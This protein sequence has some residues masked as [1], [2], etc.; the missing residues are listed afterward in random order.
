VIENLQALIEPYMANQYWRI[1]F[2]ATSAVLVALVCRLIVV[3]LFHRIARRT[4]SDM[5]EQMLNLIWPA[6]YRTIILQGVHIAAI[7]FLSAGRLE[8]TVLATTTTLMVLIW[9]RVFSGGGVV[10]FHKLSVNAERFSWIQ[11]QTLPLVQFVYKVALFSLVSYMIMAAWHVN[12]TSWLASAG[13]AG[14]ALGFAAKDTLANFVSGVFI[15]ADA[16]Y[17]VGEYIIID[18]TTRGMVTEIGMRSTRLL[19][20]DNVEVTVPNGIIGNAKIVNES[21]GPSPRMRVRVNVG[22]AYGSDIDQVRELLLECTNELDLT[23]KNATPMIRFTAMGE[24]SL[25]F[26]VLVWLRLPEFRGRV[27]NELNTRIYKALNEAGIE[28]PFPQRDLHVKSWPEGSAGQP[29]VV[30]EPDEA[31]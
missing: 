3:P 26:Q 7:D 28:I 25:D 31:S 22:V 5:D 20:R 16:P 12:L 6:I 10:V 13:V 30:Q 21:S 4:S 24:S 18:G 14:L 15:L 27:I 19:T 9:A 2:I 29:I 8:T 11:P 23:A 1:A 17:R